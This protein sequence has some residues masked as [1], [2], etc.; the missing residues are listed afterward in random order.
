MSVKMIDYIVD[1]HSIDMDRHNLN[2]VKVCA[3]QSCFCLNL[4]SIIDH[5]WVRNLYFLVI[6][7]FRFG[8]AFFVSKWTCHG[9]Q[10]TLFC[11]GLCS[12]RS[13]LVVQF[14]IAAF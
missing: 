2:R 9:H 3:T 6:I 12:F 14:V 5:A 8:K 7:S 1:E 11:T 4:M 13:R 10:E